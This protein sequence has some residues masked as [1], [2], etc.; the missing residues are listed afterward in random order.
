M[1]PRIAIWLP[2]V[3]LTAAGC[4]LA[5]VSPTA[6][7]PGPVLLAKVA[8]SASY[9]VGLQNEVAASNLESDDL[10][11][12]LPSGTGT[13]STS[14]SSSITAA[15]WTYTLAD[16]TTVEAVEL[17]DDKGTTTQQDD[18]LTITR[19]YQT[20]DGTTEKIEKIVRP[21]KP[22]RTWDGWTG[23]P[24]HLVQNGTVDEFLQGVR[25]KT[26]TL[27]VTWSR[28]GSLVWA[29]AIVKEMQWVDNKSMIDRL[30]IATDESGIQTKD[31]Y[32][33]RL[34]PQGGVTVQHIA[35]EDFEEN[36][37]VYTRG[38]LDDGSSFIIRSPKSPLVVEQ[39]TPAGILWAKN[40]QMQQG[41]S[42]SSVTEYY[43]AA[44]SIIRTSEADFGIRFLGDEVFLTRTDPADGSK[45]TL[46]I[47]ENEHGFS[48]S[49]DRAFVVWFTGGAV[50]IY[51]AKMNLIAVVTFD[52]Q[53]A[54]LV[55]YAGGSSTAVTL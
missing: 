37:V 13:S 51:D 21:P 27:T 24:M 53:G 6:S 50:N 28:N 23:N 42:T 45:M 39:Y 14:V 29:S 11:G 10:N 54:A 32:R 1:S 49:G 46:L 30:V 3:L 38:M 17:T 18:T 7:Q 44:G 48:V 43:D 8:S 34:T 26:G 31:L 33:I 52:A 55:T 41:R 36:G 22:D 4:A 25:V 19:T 47:A 5:P 9:Y 35:Y 2:V 15:A 20:W 40:T 16:G 12:E